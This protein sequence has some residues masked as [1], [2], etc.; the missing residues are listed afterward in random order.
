MASLMEG[1]IAIIG[2]LTAILGFATAL[3]DLRKNQDTSSKGDG[4]QKTFQSQ[5]QSTGVTVKIIVGIVGV[6]LMVVALLLIFTG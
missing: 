4:S 6:V 5:S 1:I 3:V 2:L